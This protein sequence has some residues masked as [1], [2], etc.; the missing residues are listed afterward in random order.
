[1]FAQILRAGGEHRAL[2]GLARTRQDARRRGPMRSGNQHLRRRPHQRINAETPRRG[3]QVAEALEKETFIEAARAADRH[4]ARHDGLISCS[5]AQPCSH[6]LDRIT[7][8]G[9]R[10]RPLTKGQ[11]IGHTD[12]GP[13]A[14]EGSIN[15]RQRIGRI[16]NPG[17]D[18]P[19]RPGLVDESQCG[20]EGHRAGRGAEREGCEEDR[21]GAR[22]GG[23]GRGRLPGAA[24]VS[25]WGGR[26]GR[27][28]LPRA[29][30]LGD[31]VGSRGL[32]RKRATEADH[33]A[34]LAEP[35][36]P[37]RCGKQRCQ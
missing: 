13:R 14:G 35:G 31:G 1:M 33:G 17:G 32:E 3:V 29:A 22:R 7:P 8:L 37:T 34:A 20:H 10:H 23:R 28:G 21:G 12:S 11:G 27:G 36:R 9:P 2:A 5:L 24:R 15:R 19:A 26:Q 30:H 25:G 18:R 4:V 16:P 6:R